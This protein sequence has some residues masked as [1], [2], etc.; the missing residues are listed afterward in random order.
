[1]SRKE[2]KGWAVGRGRTWNLK[3]QEAS[4]GRDKVDTNGRSERV[5][6]GHEGKGGGR[7]VSS[8]F[9]LISAVADNNAADGG[10]EEP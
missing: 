10:Q 8:I 7:G 1:M 4:G 2:K 3:V 5:W 9:V 6:K